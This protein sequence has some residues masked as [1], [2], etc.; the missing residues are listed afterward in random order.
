MIKKDYDSGGLKD[1]TYY[2]SKDFVRV[3][4]SSGTYDTTYVYHEGQLIA[5]KLPDGTKRYY[6]PDHLGS[7]ALITD[8]SGNEVETTTYSPYGVILSGGNAS[9]YGYESKEYDETV[10]GNDFHFRMQG[11]AGTQPFQQPD[12]IIQN[13]YDPQMLNRYSFERNSPWNR[14]DEDGHIIDWFLWISLAVDVFGIVGITIFTKQER[15]K[16]DK[17]NLNNPKKE[18]EEKQ[19]CPTCEKR[20]I[21][22]K[23][24]NIISEYWYDTK[25]EET[26]SV[27]STTGLNNINGD[28]VTTTMNIVNNDVSSK[29]QSSDGS[30][31]GGGGKPW[32]EQL[33]DWIDE[34]PDASA[35]D[36]IDKWNELL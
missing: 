1:T 22:D 35:G 3:V 28:P 34:N 25:G 21:K 4:N 23:D 20:T 36:I 10:G 27:Y 30:I 7:T 12:N 14:V 19:P 24:G 16:M 31:T 2:V 9:R 17:E 11:I 33:T 26:S 32:N 5:D 29:D 18:V 6:M 8:S 13:V 15:A